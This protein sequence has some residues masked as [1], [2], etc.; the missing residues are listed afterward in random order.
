MGSTY[1]FR[2]LMI[3]AVLA[4]P[5]PALALNAGNVV[6]ANA[7][8]GQNRTGTGTVTRNNGNETL[9]SF[10]TSACTGFSITPAETLP[11]T[12]TPG[13]TLDFT[14]AFTAP[15]RGAYSCTVTMR[16][17]IGD[18]IGTFTVSATGVAA[19]LTVST[20][21]LDFGLVKVSGGST[22]TRT[23][24]VT[25]TGDTG[26]TLSVTAIA[27]STGNTGDFSAT[28][29]TFTLNP[30]LS[31]TITVTYNPSAIG[32]RATNL[33]VTSNDPV[34]ATETL[35]LTG[36]AFDPVIATANDPTDF[37]VV[38]VGTNEAMNIAVSNTGTGTLTVQ[39]AAISTPSGSWYSFAGMPQASCNS[40]STCDFTPDLAITTAAVNVAI[41]C[42]PPIGATGTQTRTLTFTSDSA[43]GGD[44]SVTL[45]CTAGVPLI[46][47][48]VTNMAF[49]NVELAVMST[50]QSL[51]VTNTG[52]ETLSISSANFVT[53]TQ[54]A[55]AMGQTGAQTV[56]PNQTATWSLVCYPMMLGALSDTFRIASDAANSPT[57]NIP[58][59]CTGGR[60]TTSRTS[61]DFGAVR[62]GDTTTQTFTLTNTGSATISNLAAT[63]SAQAGA[64]GY[65]L[66]PATPLPASLATNATANIRVRF[67]PVD[68]TSGTQA[69]ETH[70]LRISGTYSGS[71]TTMT[72]LMNLTGDGLSAGYTFDP[73]TTFD[74]GAVRWDMTRSDR[75]FKIVNPYEAPVRITALS[76]TAGPGSST[77]ELAILGFT[78]TTLAANGGELLVTVRVDPAPNHL[79][80]ITGALNVTSDLGA[81]ITRPPLAITGAS[82]T[83]AITADPTNM[84]FD[85]GPI[86]VDRVGGMTKIFKL[87]NTGMAPLD[88]TGGSITAGLG[89]SIAA[90][91]PTTVMPAGDF[92]VT[93]TYDPTLVRPSDNATLTIG[94]GGIF[95]GTMNASFAIT[96]RGIDR[97]F[98]VTDPGLFP[99]T[100]RNPG[101][102]APVRDVVVRNTG[103]AP[104]NISAAMVTGAPVW[105][106]VDPPQ[107]A[108]Q[109]AAGGSTT[110]KVKFS[111]QTGGKAPV[112]NLV[113]THDDDTT[114]GGRAEISLE[115]FG[116]NPMLS[117]APSASISFGTTAIGFPVRLSESFID[118]LTVQNVDSAT[119]KVRVLRL[120][121]ADGETPFEL[122]SDLTGESLAPGESRKFD[123]VFTASKVGDFAAQ[124]EIYLDE[125]SE[126]ATVVQL[127]GTAVEVDVQG[128]GGCQAD[129]GGAGAALA[130]LVGGL[131]LLQRRR[132][133]RR[134]SAIAIAALAA[135]IA[136]GA[137]ALTAGAASAQSSRN[138]DLSTFRPAPAT[139]GQ[140]LQVEAPT[141]GARGDWEIGLAIS[142]T[143]NPLQVATSTGE[144]FNLVSARTM[145]DLG[146]AFA[147]A[148]RIELGARLATMNQEGDENSMV[149][150]L[151]PGV[152]TALGDALLHA[153]VAVLPGVA[154]AANVN[155]PTA[156]DDAFAG[157]GKLSASGAL[158]LGASGRRFSA[159]A[160][161]G[162]GYQDKVVLGN[163]TQGNRVLVGAGAAWRTTDA[164]WLSAE[165][166]GSVAVGQ[167]ERDSASPLEG[168]L[169]LRYRAVRT[170]DISL[171]LGTGILRGVGAP[172]MQG[173]VAF[174]LSPNAREL[175]PLRAPK[176]YVPPPDSDRDG[177]TDAADRCANEAEDLDG[178]G[179][180][181]GC[182]DL[183]NDF[184]GIADAEDKCP[185][186]GED[187]D[188]IADA[189][190]CPDND[191]DGDN[192]S[193]P[194]DKCP[195]E[196]ED[197]DGFEDT[198]GCAD[199]DDD[200]DGILDAAD[201]CPRQPETINSN[202]DG[203]GCPDAGESLVLLNAERI[204][205]VQP[206]TFVGQ[207]AK[208]TPATIN[209][210]GQVGATLRANP[211]L[212]RIRIGVHVNRRGKGDQALTEQRATAL[213]DWLV[214]WG[215]E[216]HRI[217][218][219]G[220]GSTRLIVKA[221]RKDAA[222]VNDRVELTIMERKRQ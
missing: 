186:V 202:E 193:E 86:D 135:L 113:I 53:A 168:M 132:R 109:V 80:A 57:L 185:L 215:V 173:V 116:K 105:T 6:I 222:L 128:G 85:F 65:S 46:S 201:K 26:K 27:T 97:K 30:G 76:I 147:L 219:R 29:T 25:N 67:A 187:K 11:K 99:E 42:A 90:I 133:L 84:M 163:I 115:G 214:L 206:I 114:S 125:D 142:Y 148:G 101:S 96:G 137:L 195:S 161:L 157:P 34:A 45:T 155:L 20:A 218:V 177:I 41:R 78:A 144:T 47:P 151:D 207:T 70:T 181:D 100:Y 5:L 175:A 122:S 174:E 190:G 172:G 158:L 197:L 38:T 102:K 1:Y 60:L 55:V 98:A 146:V 81:I 198:D 44:N 49:G 130:L 48:N 152:G 87:T 10:D 95:S 104:L 33:V 170:V 58:V 121:D 93:V 69:G 9:N 15:A 68:T 31:R 126:P 189:D 165:V 62:A 192:I 64:K 61:I 37:G 150:G 139:T 196:A 209:I 14:A 136:S 194:Q 79:G 182:P 19:E 107:E 138:L 21:T 112:G 77:G 66:D 51:V 156:T 180:A 127:T 108:V 83:P 123:I 120:Y 111:P 166:F 73:A 71:S 171:G 169:G 124:L 28:P 208:L 143:T 43:A 52:T 54:F 160:N 129:G 119:F 16:D 217:D 200:H 40:G 176:P 221:N 24:D 103:E 23:F 153:K 2:F 179:D 18:P 4:M 167:R 210:L 63:F 134:R 82:T 39:S 32:P 191:D 59:T 50:P 8:V 36:D 17:N 7:D 131:V 13:D 188:G 211:E 199:L 141:V 110:F 75:Q 145:F 162:F 74:A 89:Y 106:L 140:L 117:V 164:L 3:A 216:P 184:D 159:A 92:Q 91:T 12:F 204:D 212:E 22:S 118:Q 213:R 35:A 72:Q 205:L 154:L 203:D 220:F 178:F 183:D 149:S 94:V 56:M 88:I